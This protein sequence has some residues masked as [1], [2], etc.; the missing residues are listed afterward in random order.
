MMGESGSLSLA[1]YHTGD[2]S[3]VSHNNALHC[4]KE[5]LGLDLAQ[6]CLGVGRRR[7]RRTSSFSFE[8]LLVKI[9]FFALSND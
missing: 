5:N 6:T 7:R 8:H 1:F 9:Q 3:Y 4:C 2:R